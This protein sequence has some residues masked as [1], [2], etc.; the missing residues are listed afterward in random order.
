MKSSF[1]LICAGLGFTLVACGSLDG[2]TGAAPA[3]ATVNGNLTNPQSLDVTGATRVAVVWRTANGFNVAEDLPVQPVFPSSFTIQLTDPPPAD[4][5]NSGASLTSSSSSGSASSG[6]G[7]S[8][9]PPPSEEAGA[10]PPP[11]DASLSTGGSLPQDNP[12]IASNFQFAVGTVVAYLDENGNGKLDLVAPGASG[13]IDQIVA[14]NDAMSIAYFQGTIPEGSAFVDSH[15]K[16]PV[17]GYNLISIPPC[18]TVAN[19][20]SVPNPVCDGGAPD[21]GD[22]SCGQTQWLPIDTPYTLTVATT[23]QVSSAM[24]QSVDSSGLAATGTGTA[25]MDPSI[26]PPS[27]PAPCDPNLW[28]ESDGSSYQYATCTTVSK[29]ICEGFYQSCTFVDYSRPTPVPPLWPCLQ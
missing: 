6:S 19:P 20:F 16:L 4:A 13:Y 22:A 28:C 9:T 2:H 29:G 27:Y 8:G 21:A 17:D 12:I 24:C 25:P 26:Q 11:P 15:G 5:M 14:S 3:L 18:P 23:P 10:G 7:G 1:P